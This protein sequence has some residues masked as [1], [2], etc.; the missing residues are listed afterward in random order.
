MRQPRNYTSQVET[1]FDFAEKRTPWEGLGTNVAK[2]PTTSAMLKAAGLDWE[3]EKRPLKDAQDGTKIEDHF[4]LRRKTDKAVFD[5]VGKRYI[6]TQNK[7]VFDFFNAFVREGKAQMETAGALDKGRIVW[8]LAK[9]NESFTLEG[10]DKVQGYLF[11][12]SPHRQ[13]RSLLMRMTALRDVCNNTISIALRSGRYGSGDTFRMNHR[14][15]FNDEQI[16]KA[17]EVLGLAR[18]QFGEFESV[19]RKLSRLKVNQADAI[20][21]LAPIFQP[22]TPVADILKDPDKNLAPRLRMILDAMTKAPGAIPDTGWGVLNAVTYYAD[23]MASRTSDRRL[24]H[25]WVGRTANQKEEVLNKLLE[26]TR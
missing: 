15:E 6:P 5:V 2:H 10:R 11:L 25:A 22:K 3:V 18:D 19:A 12:G 20:R 23:H 4:Y 9:L 8:G 21:V 14:N 24:T 17:K 7:A 16:A 26:K 1:I 13:G